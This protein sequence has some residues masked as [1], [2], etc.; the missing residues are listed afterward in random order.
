[1]ICVVIFKGREFLMQTIQE[2]EAETEEMESQTVLETAEQEDQAGASFFGLRE[3]PSQTV[4]DLSEQEKK[5]LR[6]TY[7]DLFSSE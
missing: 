7:Q 1:M 2:E 5:A 3:C 4:L 6:E